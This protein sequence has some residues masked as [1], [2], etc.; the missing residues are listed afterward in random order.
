V[1]VGESC[2][3]APC[4]PDLEAVYGADGCTC[5]ALL[6]VGDACGV[7][8]DGYY[9]ASCGEGTY[10]DAENGETCV[11][12]HADGAACDYDGQC[13][14]DSVCNRPPGESLGTCGAPVTYPEPAVGTACLVEYGDCGYLGANG[15][16]CVDGVCTQAVVVD[17]GDVCDDPG[18]FADGAYRFCAGSATTTY[19]AIPDDA[20][21]GVCTAR[22]TLGAPCGW[23][24][25]C[26]DGDS[27]CEPDA[28]FLDWTC[29][30]LP[31]EGE[32]CLAWT[33]SCAVGLT[34]D[35]DNV[36]SPQTDAEQCTE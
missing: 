19:C 7:D 6:G 28:E 16:S 26:E 3:S 35:A 12:A 1:G 27:A 2:E 15:L 24:V 10:C 9:P 5:R 23:N 21:T 31:T 25:P 18:Y 33:Y 32:P 22:P 4:D 29:T 36:C 14:G 8:D 11:A 13:L 30:A 20:E 34:C 17:L